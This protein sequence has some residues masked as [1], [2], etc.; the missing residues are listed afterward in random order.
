MN[1]T[2]F[3]IGSLILS[4][5]TGLLAQEEQVQDFSGEIGGTLLQLAGALLLIIVIIYASVWLMKR[6]TGG[7]T[8]LGGDLIKVIERRHLSPKQAIYVIK[9][10]ERHVLLGATETGINKLCDVEIP[11]PPT[12]QGKLPETASSSSK[13]SQFLKQAR[14][15]LMP[16][17]SIEQK[18]ADA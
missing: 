8:S 7:R 5:N 2:I 12:S 3:S 10:G 17:N 13:F 14:E 11:L 6:Y 9:V 18:G 15:S 1:R 16:R 4:L